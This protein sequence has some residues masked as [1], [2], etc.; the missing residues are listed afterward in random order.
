M[1]RGDL[2]ML[3]K[4]VSIK[5]KLILL[6]IITAVIVLVLTAAAFVINDIA[7]FKKSL[8]DKLSSTALIIGENSL[9][10]LQFL[11]EDAEYSSTQRLYYRRIHTSGTR[12]FLFLKNGRSYRRTWG[13]AGI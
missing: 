7:V 12:S 1:K 8:I 3:L 13:I 4:N 6:Q 9:S 2:T 5:R 10:A 11:D